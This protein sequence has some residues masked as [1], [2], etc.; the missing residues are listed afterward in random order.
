MA[1]QGDADGAVLPPDVADKILAHAAAHGVYH[2][3]GGH[4]LVGPLAEELPQYETVH[5]AFHG[6]HWLPVAMPSLEPVVSVPSAWPATYGEFVGAVDAV[7][8]GLFAEIFAPAGATDLTFTGTR[9][10]VYT[11]PRRLRKHGGRWPKLSQS[12][13]VSRTQRQAQPVTLHLR[14]YLDATMQPAG[15]TATVHFRA[16]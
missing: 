11:G 7:A 6:T 10:R 1:E 8:E 3:T 4:L 14:G 12:R 15:R 16:A 5:L 13:Y 2:G 9:R